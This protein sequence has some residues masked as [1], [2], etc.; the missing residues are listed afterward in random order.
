MRATGQRDHLSAEQEVDRSAFSRTFR[1]QLW[2]AKIG[3]RDGILSPSAIHA[4]ENHF[5]RDVE[6]LAHSG[7]D[8]TTVKNP[9]QKDKLLN[10]DPC[11]KP[12]RFRCSHPTIMLV[13]APQ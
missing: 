2:Q 8:P 10:D 5:S 11:H 7:H 13:A 1:Q 12:A 4:I 3:R 9:P 6:P